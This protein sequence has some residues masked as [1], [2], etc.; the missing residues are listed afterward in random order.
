MDDTT[1][2]DIVACPTPPPP[3]PPPIR[4]HKPKR[5]HKQKKAVIPV[6]KSVV[7]LDPVGA[8]ADLESAPEPEPTIISEP[9][10]LTVPIIES[11]PEPTIVSPTATASEQ[12]IPEP[13]TLSE[14]VLH[15]SSE[16]PYPVINTSSVITTPTP[17]TLPISSEV[18]YVITAEGA[19]KHKVDEFVNDVVIPI[20]CNESVT[21]RYSFYSLVKT[22]QV[23]VFEGYAA[24]LYKT[25][26]VN[27]FRNSSHS[28]QSNR[29]SSI[30]AICYWLYV[31]FIEPN[32]LQTFTQ[33]YQREVLVK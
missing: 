22:V 28:V 33:L 26:W 11:K 6:V 5:Y 10:T 14:L 3:I 27:V 17:T 18:P 25:I 31:R 4:T 15:V 19:Q 23:L 13:S 21:T 7:V 24:R 2:L 32:Q 29:I 8:C 16:I 20:L 1:T 12:T 30:D 9:G